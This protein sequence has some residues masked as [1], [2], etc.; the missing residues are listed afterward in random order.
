MVDLAWSSISQ[1][2]ILD[3]WP[4]RPPNRRSIHLFPQS[5]GLEMRAAAHFL[6]FMHQLIRLINIYKLTFAFHSSI[7]YPLI[8]SIYNIMKLCRKSAVHNRRDLQGRPLNHFCRTRK[9]LFMVPFLSFHASV[10][11]LIRRL[12]D[13]QSVP[14]CPMRQKRKQTNSF[15]VSEV[16]SAELFLSHECQETLIYLSM[17]HIYACIVS[18]CTAISVT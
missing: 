6:K 12:I 15:S 16:Y 14:Y 13:S 7:L 1:L 11:Q 18:R 9:L 2:D 4:Y 17:M 10:W 5:P 8:T 3:S